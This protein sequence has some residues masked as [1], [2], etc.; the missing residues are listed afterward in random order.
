MDL[1][2]FMELEEQFTHADTDGKIHLY[3]ETEGLT[4]DQYKTLLKHFP[5]DALG[6]LEEALD[7]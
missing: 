6:K 1:Q 3:V 7:G 5:Y 4:Q 2:N